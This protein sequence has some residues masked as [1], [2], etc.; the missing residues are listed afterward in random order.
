MHETLAP[1]RFYWAVLSPEA[2]E[3]GAIMPDPSLSGS[4]ALLLER[5][6]SQVPVDVEMLATAFIGLPGGSVLACGL[7]EGELSQ[8]PNAVT[9]TPAALP[10]WLVPELASGTDPSSLNVLT[11]RYE[12]QIVVRLRE[13]RSVTVAASVA[14]IA[15]LAVF[16][17]LRRAHA[18][19]TTI[20][21]A[22][23][24]VG[25]Q[26]QSS[27]AKQLGLSVAKQDD[28]AIA[29]EAARLRATRSQQARAGL[30]DLTPDLE[31]VLALWPSDVNSQVQ[32]ITADG[33]QLR[34]TATVPTLADAE[35][36][37]SALAK[38]PGWEASQPQIASTS[39]N[40]QVQ[41]T[42]KA[43]GKP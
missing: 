17:S 5:L 6:Q 27:Q 42:L 1:E 16:G 7:S 43:G 33:A 38:S 28:A 10:P 13:K 18:A 41:L 40:L 31:R 34:I 25:M 4:R 8:F 24:A 23:Q 32:S 22:E 3:P 39:K 36:L 11:G 29:R 35:K 26:Y 30:M 21:Q 20:E 37:A 14:L 2:G 15:G 9:L 19:G 12:P